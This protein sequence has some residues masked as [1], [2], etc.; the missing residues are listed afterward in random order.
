MKIFARIATVLYI[1]AVPVFLVTA[2]VRFVA[3]DSR[4]SKNG[5]RTYD[6]EEITGVS[7]PQL[8]A[9]AEDIVRYFEDDRSVLR[10]P[11]TINGQETSLFNDKETSHMQDVKTLIR[12]VFRLNELS[13]A[14]ILVYVGAV[15]LWSRERSLRDLARYSLMG[16]GVGV[17]F[18]GVVSS[19]A[20][21]GGFDK[22]WTQFHELV[23]RNNLWELDPRKDRLIQMF[24]EPFWRKMTF[25]VGGL[26][27]A[28]ALAVVGVSLSY[29]V[30]SRE[31]KERQTPVSSAIQRPT[32]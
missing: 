30:I 22:A 7:L 24:P 19:F 26:T 21:T 5:F 6:V 2:N 23:F 25:V 3:G 15:V 32:S 13:L 4:F 10:I 8:D 16:V 11:V 14:M 28:E 1:I 29:L 18:V 27:I 17:L 12:L 31:R 9:A 20:I